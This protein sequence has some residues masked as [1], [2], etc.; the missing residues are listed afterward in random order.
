[1]LKVAC[2]IS[3][4]CSFT[5]QQVLFDMMQED[6]DIE[7]TLILTSSLLEKKNECL[8]NSIKSKYSV[9]LCELWGYSGSL[10]TMASSLSTLS[11]T[12]FKALVSLEP[13]VAIV[14]AD[15][16]ELLPFASVVSYL[17]IPLVHIQAFETSGNID[18]KV[19]GAVSALADVHLT[20]HYHATIKGLASGYRKVYTT[21]CP[22]ID[23]IKKFE[24]TSKGGYV[25]L[26]YHPLTTDLNASRDIKTII[27]QT[28]WYCDKLSLKLCCF[29][30]N[31]DPGFKE[32]IENSSE[33][34]I[35]NLEGDIFYKLLAGASAIV[36][37]SSAGIREAS[38]FGVKAINI[39]DRQKGRMRAGN[40][41]DCDKEHVY[42]ALCEDKVI[43]KSHLFGAGY[44]SEKI[45][46]IIKGKPWEKRN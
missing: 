46:E 21:G 12:Y 44:A 35:Y 38:Y 45:I 15:R 1:M 16:F 4:R 28:R 3:N 25:I 6:P 43:L 37:N 10:R 31:N 29:A 20:S 11:E 19:R 33:E 30:P 18:D 26:M 40:V 2:L 23:Y 36:G 34:L 27:E 17:N 24:G 9:I 13:D 5:R 32:V 41:I 14:I 39:G 8:C 22:S 42:E 7:L